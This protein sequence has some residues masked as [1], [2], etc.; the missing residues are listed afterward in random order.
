MK[1]NKKT[2]P[3]RSLSIPTTKLLM[4]NY[5]RL[6]E[7]IHNKN[8]IYKKNENLQ[9][10]KKWNSMRK[11]LMTILKPYLILS[12][13]LLIFLKSYHV[14]TTKHHLVSQ[15]PTYFLLTHTHTKKEHS[16]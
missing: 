9:A 5:N 4:E 12:F 2:F 15:P 3:C 8:K 16:S 14:N 11:I 13:L 10:D 7:N 6:R 1:Q